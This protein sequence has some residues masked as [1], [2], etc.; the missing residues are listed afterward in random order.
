MPVWTGL[1]RNK[2]WMVE[3]YSPLALRRWMSFKPFIVIQLSLF[4]EECEPLLRRCRLNIPSLPL[5]QPAMPVISPIGLYMHSKQVDYQRSC[6]AG[7]RSEAFCR[8]AKLNLPI[9]PC[10]PLLFRE[11]VS[12]SAGSEKEKAPRGIQGAEGVHEEQRLCLLRLGFRA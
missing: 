4:N 1:K 5:S 11:A 12:A 8:L 9:T 10:T 7:D 2:K 3:F 6:Y